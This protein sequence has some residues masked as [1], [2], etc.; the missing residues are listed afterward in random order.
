[1]RLLGENLKSGSSAKKK[2]ITSNPRLDSVCLINRPEILCSQ[3]VSPTETR[4]IDFREANSCKLNVKSDV[5]FQRSDLQKATSTTS[6][7]TEI[8]LSAISY[9][10]TSAPSSD[11]AE[12]SVDEVIHYLTSIDLGLGIHAPLF[13]KH[14]KC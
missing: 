9:V 4:D 12:W 10:K 5:G 14:V 6:T 1:M 8:S 13:Q 3:S 7:E 11:P 2:K